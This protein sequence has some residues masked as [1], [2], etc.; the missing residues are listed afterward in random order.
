M[1]ANDSV[2]TLQS[3]LDDDPELMKAV[4]EAIQDPKRRE[5]LI[6]FLEKVGLLPFDQLLRAEQ[7]PSAPNH[8]NPAHLQ[9]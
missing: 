1:K 9:K 3:I 2:A 7:R 6:S 8:Y 4:E 5:E